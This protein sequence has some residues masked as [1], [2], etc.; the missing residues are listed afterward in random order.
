MAKKKITNPKTGMERWFV[1]A[2]TGTECIL[3]M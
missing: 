1:G 2:S 3:G